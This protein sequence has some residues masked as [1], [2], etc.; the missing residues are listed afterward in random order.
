MAKQKKIINQDEEVLKHYESYENLAGKQTA[1]EEQTSIETSLFKQPQLKE[2]LDKAKASKPK[3]VKAKI[4]VDHLM[5][6][7]KSATIK[8]PARKKNS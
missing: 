5:S 3:F 1:S 2:L 6:K 8:D 7:R 4:A